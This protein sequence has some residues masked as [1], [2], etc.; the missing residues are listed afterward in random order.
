MTQLIK[1]KAGKI[2]PAM[3]FVA[4]N[5]GVR[6]EVIRSEVE[7]GRIV[8]PKNKQRKVKFSQGFGK[9]L[10]TKVNTSVGLYRD[11]TDI[12][13]E[14]KKVNLAV[15]LGT[16][17]VM[18]L[19]K[20]GDI[21]S[22]RREVLKATE[23]PVG[24]LPIYQAAKESQEKTESILNMTVDDIF[25]IVE[26]QAEDGV[27]FMGIHAGLR[28]EV[29]ER[30]KFEGR[31]EGLVSHGGQILAGWM[32]HNQQ[33]N[34]FYK[35]YDRL[36]EI[37]KRY[38][39]TLS[40][41]DTFRPGAISDSLDRAQIQELIILGELVDQGRDYGVQMMVKGPG[42]VP[43]DQI[44]STIQLQKELCHDAPYFVFGPLVTDLATG[45]DDINSAIGGAFAAAAG[46]DFLCYVTPVEHLDFPTEE[47]IRDGVMAA[48]IAA[49]VGDLSKGRE[50]AWRKE[51]KM[52]KARKEL[53]WEAEINLSL[54]P[55]NAKQVREGRNPAGSDGCAMCGEYCAIKVV[56]GYLN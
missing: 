2:T 10:R 24:T 26:K 1:A 6:P 7:A 47:D 50:E 30:L 46:A 45:E 27:D 8:I 28:L 36:L 5:E 33:E 16:D 19:S 3:K 32:L 55:E 29:L 43:L 38:D 21:D 49:Q 35:E 4:E 15:S 14:L 39:V 52:A 9:G 48:K 56:D 11:Y 12:Q 44:K 41:A 20:D 23:L 37:A 53:N 42:H 34:P 31:V 13:T 22:A 51:E 40:L 25:K 54:N 17:A 18:D